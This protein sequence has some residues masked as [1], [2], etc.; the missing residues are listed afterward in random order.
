MSKVRD[1]W[2][3]ITLSDFDTP[4]QIIADKIYETLKEKGIEAAAFAYSID[5]DYM[6]IEDE[7]INS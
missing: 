6:E 4:D 2:K 1:N 3:N 5:I 7:K